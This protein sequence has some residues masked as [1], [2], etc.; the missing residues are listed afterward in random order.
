[1]SDSKNKSVIESSLNY[2]FTGRKFKIWFSINSSLISFY[3]MFLPIILLIGY[4]MDVRE[5]AYKG[6]DIPNFENYY[7]LAEEGYYALVCYSPLVFL[8]FFCIILYFI[9]IPLAIG[10]L[11]LCIYI[12]PA[13]S[14]LYSVKRDYKLVYG[15]D[16]FD[17][18]ASEKYIKYWMI[19]SIFN[20]ITVFI[21]FISLFATFGLSFFALFPIFIIARSSYWGYIMKE[22]QNIKTFEE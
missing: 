1:M 2:I 8:I 20:V 9:Y 12:W 21:I 14:I 18:V 16:L 10:I 6:E 17:I 19:Y 4:L 5:S 22:I 7:E 11:S 3:V 13:V 15:G